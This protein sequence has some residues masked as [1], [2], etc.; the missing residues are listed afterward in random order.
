MTPEGTKEMIQGGTV[1]VIKSLQRI[2]FTLGTFN[3]GGSIQYLSMGASS[4]LVSG[5]QADPSTGVLLFLL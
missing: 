4:G 5:V 2:D 3:I 1:S